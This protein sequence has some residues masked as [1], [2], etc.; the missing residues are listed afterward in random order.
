[1]V[2]MQPGASNAVKVCMNVQPGERVVILSDQAREA[3]G[4]ALDAECEAIGAASKVL[5]MEDFMKRPATGLPSTL[6]DAIASFRPTV[7]F[8]AAQALPGELTFRRPYMD[9]VIYEMKLRHGHMV[10]ITEPLMLQGMEAD[11]K[12]IARVTHRVTEAV[13]GARQIEVTAP[14][15]T[16]MRA[17]FD[18]SKRKWQ[19]CPGLYHTQGEWGN[20]PEGET[21][22]SPM[23][24]DGV[25]GAEV[26]GDHFSEKYG[27]LSKPAKFELAGGRV[28][29]VE[30]ED[31]GLQKEL[32]TYLAQHE[33]SNRVGE[34]AIGTNIALKELSGN[35]LQDEKVPG[36]HIAFGYPYPE[37]TGADW[38]CPSHLD[39]VA[40]R[41]TIK[42]DGQYLMKEGVF[43]I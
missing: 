19:P 43:V 28:R 31:D 38:T 12:E 36:V 14:S 16:D 27:I 2:D 9:L 7:S 30:S 20:L 33:N 40:T 26:L 17:T 25:M 3:I 13:R 15:G 24:V 6:T 5:L 32:E 22:T 10:G 4:R 8:Y 11:Y 1:M 37:E 29:R 35:L 41:S 34:Y 23:S 42:V 18:P 21:F 39:G